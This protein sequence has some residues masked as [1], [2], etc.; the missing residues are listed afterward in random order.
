MTIGYKMSYRNLSFWLLAIFH[1]AVY[2]WS[3]GHVSLIFII[4]III[5]HKYQTKIEKLSFVMFMAELFLSK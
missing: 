5:C 4:N 3:M 1:K 2:N